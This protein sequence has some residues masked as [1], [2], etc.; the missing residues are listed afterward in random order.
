MFHSV[1]LLAS[2]TQ[3]VCRYWHHVEFLG[4]GGM[5][6]SVPPLA[7]GTQLVCRHWHRVEIF[8]WAYVP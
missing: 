7:S 1:P 8:V 3:L 6:L 4:S 2:G 5:F